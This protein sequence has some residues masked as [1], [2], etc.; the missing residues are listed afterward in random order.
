MPSHT[1]LQCPDIAFQLS[2]QA[3]QRLLELVIVS[4]EKSTVQD[5]C[6]QRN[7]EADRT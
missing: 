1:S 4:F 2:L 3:T 7:E 5:T 6:Q